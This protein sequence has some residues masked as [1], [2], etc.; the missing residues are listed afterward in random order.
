MKSLSARGVMRKV[1]EAIPAE[2]RG[3]IIV[4]GSLAVAYHFFGKS[5]GEVTTKDVDGMLSPRAHAIHNGKAIAERLF[6]ANW[7]LRN[8]PEWNTPGNSSTPVA[9]LP[10]LRLNPP[11]SDEW[12]LELA[13]APAEGSGESKTLERLSTSEGDFALYSFRFLALAEEDPLA[14]EFGLL[15]ARPEMIAL[16]N[17]LHHPRIGTHRW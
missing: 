12:F 10:F 16:A 8:D 11:D 5:D 4:V 7:K 15:Y 14:T 9:K 13:S 6:E 17:L 1:A 2:C 3:E